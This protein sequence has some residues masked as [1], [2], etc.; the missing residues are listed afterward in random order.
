MLL[1]IGIQDTK[2]FRVI[3]GFKDMQLMR[4][5]FPCK[6]LNHGTQNN[7]KSISSQFDCLNLCRNFCFNNSLL[8]LLILDYHYWDGISAF[9]HQSL[10]YLLNSYSKIT[11]QHGLLI[12]ILVSLSFFEQISVTNFGIQFP[13][14]MQ[15]ICGPCER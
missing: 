6:Y 12:E 10:N 2:A 5:V 9:S 1:S 15:S 4:T 13:F 11:F 3:A 8:F 7:H 14:H